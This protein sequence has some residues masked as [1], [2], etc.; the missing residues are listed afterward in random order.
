M[1][2][3]GLKGCDAQDRR[4]MTEE[5]VVEEEEEEGVEVV[6]EEGRGAHQNNVR[7]KFPLR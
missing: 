7:L 1:F 3:G 6:G 5:A 2:G 4:G